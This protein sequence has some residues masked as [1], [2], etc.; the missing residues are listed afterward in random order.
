MH[1]DKDKQGLILIN[2]G[3]GKGKTTAALGQMLR[4][5]GWKLRVVMFQFIKKTRLGAGEHRAAREFGLDIRS[6]GTGFTWNAKDQARAKALAM[7]QWQDCQEAMLSGKFDM[8]VIDE[9]SY[10]L[11][12]DW[13]SLSEVI[14]TI[15]HRPQGMHLLLT[16]RNMPQ[17]LIDIADLVT[18]M[19]EIKHPYKNGMKAQKGIE[20]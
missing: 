4:A 17:Q 20:F 10:P 3:N 5:R 16:G 12:S 7:E 19:T 1:K 8:I 15:Q 18:E 11:N 6:L 13:I 14:D 2:T 9:V